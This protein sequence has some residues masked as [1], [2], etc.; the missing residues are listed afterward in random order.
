MEDWGTGTIATA[1]DYAPFGEVTANGTAEQPFQW[2]SE[3][4]DTEL[5][6][7]YY[8]FRFYNP[9]DGKW[10]SRD[11]IGEKGGWNLYDFL[12]NNTS[13]WTDYRGENNSEDCKKC[14]EHIKQKQKLYA[15]MI[16]EI[17]KKGCTLNFMCA[18]LGRETGKTVRLDSAWWPFSSIK[19]TIVLDCCTGATQP[20]NSPEDTF[21]HE[22]EHAKD[23]CN[24]TMK[25]G[26]EGKHLR[27]NKGVCDGIL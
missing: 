2:S 16:K 18:N 22:L 11:P 5:G 27:R 21:G 19:I 15:T 6:M 14:V 17:K 10:I 25:S 23:H 7:V 8:N 9:L 20:M 3:F 26:C 4:Y 12:G 13:K 24:G 1:Y